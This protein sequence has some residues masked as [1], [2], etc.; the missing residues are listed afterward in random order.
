[1]YKVYFTYRQTEKNIVIYRLRHWS[2]VISS[3]LDLHVP[4]LTLSSPSCKPSPTCCLIYTLLSA[5]ETSAG[6]FDTV[7]HTTL[8]QEF[9][10][11]DIP[12]A[13]YNWL[14]DFCHPSLAL[15]DIQ[16]LDIVAATD[17][18]QH[19]TW[20]PTWL[21]DWLGFVRRQR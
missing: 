11:L 7:R 1:M 12:D 21:G 19:C 17:L 16:R 9:V 8:L 6:R 14:V 5:V 10:Q 20:R 4:S 15:H 3:H 13:V 2:S 18:G